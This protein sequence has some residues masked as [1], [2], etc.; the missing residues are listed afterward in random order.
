MNNM[1]IGIPR[2]LSAM[3]ILPLLCWDA[4]CSEH[5]TVCHITK[6]LIAF[7]EV[8]EETASFPQEKIERNN[9]LKKVTAV[10]SAVKTKFTCTQNLQ[11]DWR[12]LCV[13]M[14]N[15]AS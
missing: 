2:T 8:W 13:R 7:T 10:S 9:N 1:P 15:V 6:H 14:A 12:S 11:D 3:A 5:F 4:A